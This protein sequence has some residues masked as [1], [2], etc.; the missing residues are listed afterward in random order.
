MEIEIKTALIGVGATIAG[1]ILGWIL[2]EL[3]NLGKLNIFVSFWQDEFQKLEAGH[4]KSVNTKDD[5]ECYS[6]K[7]TID[8]YNSSSSTKIMRNIRIVFMKEIEELHCSKPFDDSSREV[9]GQYLP[10]VYQHL[11]VLNISPKSVISISFHDGIWYNESKDVNIDFLWKTKSIYIKYEDEK[12]ET[13][14]FKIKDVDFI[15]SFS[16]N[17]VE[18]I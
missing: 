11:N 10:A 16:E 7:G 2:N 9:T 18:K 14:S 15:S 8:I 6:Y 17:E 3:S 13:K 12:G 5:V 1:T 4:M